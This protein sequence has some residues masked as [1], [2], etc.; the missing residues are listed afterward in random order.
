MGL[1]EVF[2]PL[3]PSPRRVAALTTRLGLPSGLKSRVA[4]T[5]GATSRG[6]RKESMKS[7]AIPARPQWFI[8]PNECERAWRRDNAAR[9]TAIADEWRRTD[10]C[11][12]AAGSLSSGEHAAV[13]IV[14]RQTTALGDPVYAFLMLDDWMQKWILDSKGLSHLTGMPIAADPWGY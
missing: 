5:G 9:L 7:I 11:P 3:F 14:A 12:D 1:G 13:C 8:E 6:H 4:Y 2:E 10:A